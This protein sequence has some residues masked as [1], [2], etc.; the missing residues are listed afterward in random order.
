MMG[1]F[2]EKLRS[3][4]I[5]SG[6]KLDLSPVPPTSASSADINGADC[7]GVSHM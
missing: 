3:A 4:G 2:Q 7:L 6:E 5:R 1:C